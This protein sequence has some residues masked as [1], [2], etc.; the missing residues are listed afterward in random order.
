MRV[1]MVVLVCLWPAL[2]L[3]QA[4]PAPPEYVPPAEQK[5]PAP[6]ASPF[7]PPPAP[8]APAPDPTPPTGRP[9]RLREQPR[10]R[11]S[12]APRLSVRIGDGPDGLPRVGYGA[13]VHLLRAIGVFGPIRLGLGASFAY[14]RLAVDRE[15]GTQALAHYSFAAFGVLDTIVD[16]VR[17]FLTVGG[18]LSAGTYREPALVAGDKNLDLTEAVGLIQLGAGLGVRVYQGFEVGLRGEL[19]LTFSGTAVGAQLR[20]PFSPGIFAAALDLAAAF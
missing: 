11:M 2:A 17:P 9:L 18:G 1:R 6:P 12:V 16:R 10:W 20:H 15:T 3:G 13:G 8:K 5:G 4:E 7:D 19:D 14:D